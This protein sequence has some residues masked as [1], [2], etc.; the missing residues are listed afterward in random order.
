M[1]IQY[2]HNRTTRDQVDGTLALEVPTREFLEQMFV[3]H[4]NMTL[5]NIG[6][7]VKSK[8]DAFVKKEGRANA[9]KRM[10]YLK[11]ELDNIDQDGTTHVYRF[12]TTDMVVN[13]KKYFISIMLSTVK[14]SDNVRFVT[15]YIDVIGKDDE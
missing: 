4:G 5:F 12:H 9:E 10:G 8:K 13:R 2:A 14:E 11:F 6:L 1:S 15:G 7:S 3:S